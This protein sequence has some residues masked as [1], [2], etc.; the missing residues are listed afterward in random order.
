[1]RRHGVRT[2][3]ASEYLVILHVSCVCFDRI[4]NGRQRAER[5]EELDAHMLSYAYTFW[6]FGARAGARSEIGRA[7]CRERV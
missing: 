4:H 3:G 6:R 1:M 2:V 5:I 7:S